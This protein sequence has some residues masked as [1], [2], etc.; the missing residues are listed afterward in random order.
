MSRASPVP[1]HTYTCGKAGL[2]WL[3]LGCPGSCS[4]GGGSPPSCTGAA[5]ASAEPAAAAARRAAATAA[6]RA[7]KALEVF[8]EVRVSQNTLPSGSIL[9][10]RDTHLVPPKGNLRKYAGLATGLVRHEL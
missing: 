2:S 8:L 5:A 10:M 4:L 7:L 9:F 3:T 1:S 6:L